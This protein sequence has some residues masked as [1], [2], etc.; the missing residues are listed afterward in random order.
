MALLARVPIAV[1]PATASRPARP[2]PKASVLGVTCG[3][4]A[5]KRAR[6][7]VAARVLARETEARRDEGPGNKDTGLAHIGQVLE[8]KRETEVEVKPKAT[9]TRNLTLWP[10]I[11]APCH[12]VGG[13]KMRFSRVED[14][15]VDFGGLPIP[16]RL[17]DA[18]TERGI[19]QPSDIQE[20][21]M[22]KLSNGEHI[23][24][25]A[26]TGGGK[27]LSYLLPMWLGK[28]LET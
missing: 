20:M 11:T 12:G 6:A 9:N 2:R 18:F 26:P 17:A 27:T 25:H 13:V 24:I 10:G 21:V 16:Q 8:D 22:P 23:I 5:A 3:V 15:L 1:H 14:T 28:V 7:L 4:L 19:V